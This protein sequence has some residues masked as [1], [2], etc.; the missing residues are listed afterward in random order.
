MPIIWAYHRDLQFLSFIINS[1]FNIYVVLRVYLS[2][3]T[4]AEVTLVAVQRSSDNFH[5]LKSFNFNNKQHV[6]CDTSSTCRKPRLQK[7]NADL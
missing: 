4:G 2:A 6:S 5:Q 3:D 7:I 1:Q